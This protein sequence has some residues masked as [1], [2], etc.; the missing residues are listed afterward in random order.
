MAIFFLS[1][2]P[3]HPKDEEKMKVQSVSMCTLLPQVFIRRSGCFDISWKRQADGRRVRS[4]TILTSGKDIKSAVDG[5]ASVPDGVSPVEFQRFY[6]LL[7]SQS[8][9]EVEAKTLELVKNGELSEGLLQAALATL[10]QAQRKQDERVLPT[11]SGLCNYLIEVYQQ[12]NVPRELALVDG[13]VQLIR[14]DRDA[15][16]NRSVVK[17]AMTARL[18]VEDA[19]IGVAEFLSSV[20]KYLAA[21][22]EQDNEFEEGYSRLV[23][24][25]GMTDV[26]KD[27]LDQMR[28]LRAEA[29]GH[30][31][32]VRAIAGELVV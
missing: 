22:E 26:Q 1:A 16:T 12:N 5:A 6:H 27:Q 8:F 32:L 9:E 20:E 4:R 25:G 30:M 2:Q 7:E 21:M 31:R 24:E 10:E 15:E 18:L 23:E 11:L 29:K 17:D 28:H 14:S 3:M 13:F 19:E